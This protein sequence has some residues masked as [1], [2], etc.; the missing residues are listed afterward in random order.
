MNSTAQFT[1]EQYSEIQNASCSIV[2]LIDIM[3]EY[4]E[5]NADNRKIAILLTILEQ[6]KMQA[7]RINNKF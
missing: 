7:K 3:Y 6:T 1:V 5:H 4:C 2:D